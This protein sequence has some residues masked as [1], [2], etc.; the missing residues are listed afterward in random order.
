M[1]SKANFP[2]F[3]MVSK[4]LEMVSLL[5]SIHWPT[6]VTRPRAASWIWGMCW[7]S[8]S[9]NW[10]L[11]FISF[12]PMRSVARPMR[13]WATATLPASV[14]ARA[15]FTPPTFW[16]STSA[17]VAAFCSSVPVFRICSW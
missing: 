12:S 15:L 9:A 5:F 16:A 4:A 2:T 17:R 11:M 10:P 3:M 7:I 8:R 13:F 1:V 6:R 14:S